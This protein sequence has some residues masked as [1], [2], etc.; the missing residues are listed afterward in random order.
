[1]KRVVVCAAD[2]SEE[3]ETLTVVDLLRRAEIE[4]D[5]ISAQNRGKIKS[6]HG[7]EITTDKN[8]RDVDFKSYD[9]IVIP[10]G[11]RGVENLENNVFVINA[12]QDANERGELVA[13]ICAGPTV[14]GKAG[15]LHGVKSTVYPGMD[16]QL[17]GAEYVDCP[18]IV[19]G[20]IITGRSMA[21]S[22]EFALAIIKE[23]LDEATAKKVAGGIVY[24][25]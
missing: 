10:G 8:I 9:G 16:K 17:N 3:V 21:A 23:L 1:M 22:C 24:E 7:I 18:V 6:S 11:L 13:A 15:I 5:L 20:N 4:V 14:L 2:G 25:G 12:L 19:D